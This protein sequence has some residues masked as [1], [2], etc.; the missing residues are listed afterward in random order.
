MGATMKKYILLYA[1]V[2][3]IF[4]LGIYFTLYCGQHLAPPSGTI[5]IGLPEKSGSMEATHSSSLLSTIVSNLQEPLS[6]LI[7]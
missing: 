1:I 3:I 2:I 4:S 6:Q 7:L 5:H